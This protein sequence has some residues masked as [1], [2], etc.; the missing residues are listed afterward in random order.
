MDTDLTLTSI[1]VGSLLPNL[2]AVAIQPGW[3][4]EVRGLAAFG[5]CI[6]A[7][8]VV[9]V[10]QGEIGDGRTL[11]ASVVGVLVTSQVLY[12]TLWKPSGIAPIIERATSP[13]AT[14]LTSGG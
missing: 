5:I 11:A 12:T 1:V 10:L 3:R 4:K 2:I 8:T 6:V 14:R 9:A 7:G 13:V